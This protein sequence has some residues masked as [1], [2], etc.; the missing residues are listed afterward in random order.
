MQALQLTMCYL[1]RKSQKITWEGNLHPIS[2]PEKSYLRFKLLSSR[3]PM[4][5]NCPILAVVLESLQEGADK[6]ILHY[7]IF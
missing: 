3:F 2:Q 5:T 7:S 6:L 1:S 4:D